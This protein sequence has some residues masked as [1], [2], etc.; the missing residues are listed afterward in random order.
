[1]YSYTSGGQVPLHQIYVSTSFKELVKRIEDP[2]ERTR[3][4]ALH[5]KPGITTH[6]C[7]IQLEPSTFSVEVIHE[8]APYTL[9]S[10]V[11]DLGGYL[12]LLALALVLLFPLFFE[13]TKPRTFFAM[14]LL[15]KWQRRGQK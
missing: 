1:V 11:S 2:G 14:W 15:H 8:V 3:I 6:L 5:A 7:R 13:P 9:G 4:E 10:F 12:N